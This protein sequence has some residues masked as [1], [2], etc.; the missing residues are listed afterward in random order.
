LSGAGTH[1]HSL[2]PAVPAALDPVA[3]AVQARLDAIAPT[4]Q[5]AV[6]A[7]AARVQAGGG[8]RVAVRGGPICAAIEV[9]LDAI[10]ADIEAMFDAL[11]THIEAVVGPI[12]GIGGEGRGGDGGQQYGQAQRDAVVHGVASWRVVGTAMLATGETPRRRAR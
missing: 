1:Q 5:L 3:A 4:V 8:A 2:A 7:L 12:A 11:A 9:P 10:A 6:D